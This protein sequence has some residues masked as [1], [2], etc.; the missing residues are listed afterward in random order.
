MIGDDDD[1][2]TEDCPLN[3]LDVLQ[4]IHIEL[5]TNE[6][7]RQLLQELAN[8]HVP[9]TCLPDLDKF[10]MGKAA[11]PSSSKPPT[12]ETPASDPSFGASPIDL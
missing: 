9:F 6:R 2:M 5:V 11:V 4:S 7:E 8:N 12:S 3:N 10:I 1:E